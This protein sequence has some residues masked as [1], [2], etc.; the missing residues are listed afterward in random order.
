LVKLKVVVSEKVMVS[1]K[2]A[3]ELEVELERGAVSVQEMGKA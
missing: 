1:E 2:V 3:E